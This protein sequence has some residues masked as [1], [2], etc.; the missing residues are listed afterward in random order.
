M[1][2]GD[3]LKNIRREKHISQEELADKLGVSRQSV[4]KWENGENYPSM[5][6][7]MCLCTIFKCK[8]NDIVHEDMSDIKSLDEDL[9]MKVSSLNKEKQKKLKAISKV[10]QV[11]GII[12]KIVARIG[13]GVMAFM[14]IF[15]PI[16]IT[17]TKVDS[18]AKTV[19]MFGKKLDLKEKG[20]RLVYHEDGDNVSIDKITLESYE[21]GIKQYG[22]LLF[23]VFVEIGIIT[24]IALLVCTAKTM[25]HLEKL[26]KNINSGDTPF[27]LENVDHIKKM[28]Y[29][30]I[31]CIALSAISSAVFHLAFVR[32]DGNETITFDLV[33]ILFLFAIAYIF[34]YGYGLQAE[35]KA[36]LYD[37]E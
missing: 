32:L 26:F 6:N 29:F 7:I 25:G 33:H 4:S 20:E 12:G 5:Q 24:V 1:K 17:N 35:S 37:S 31:A 18:E 19:T 27:T 14:L 15:T 11:L 30:M 34:E 13:V 8:M 16:M 10:L 9:Q 21:R 22:E 2:F 23:I 28:T 36:K 3:N